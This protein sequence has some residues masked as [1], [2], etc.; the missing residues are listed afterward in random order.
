MGGLEKLKAYRKNNRNV[1][2]DVTAEWCINCKMNKKLVLDN[3]EVQ[4]L[5]KENN[6]VLLRADWTFPDE[7]IL[8][9]LKEHKRYG[10]PFNIYFSEQFKDGYIFSEIL[11]K[12]KLFNVLHN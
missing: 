3:K 4:K 8:N 11:T 5:F 9:F 6:I 12:T 10:I 7:R 1:F 2:I